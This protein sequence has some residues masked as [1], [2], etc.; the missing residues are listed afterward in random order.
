MKSWPLGIATLESALGVSQLANFN[1]P[2]L[3]GATET[4]RS[5]HLLN[6]SNLQYITNLQHVD[7]PVVHVL[8]ELLE[9][10][11]PDVLE[12]DDRVLVAR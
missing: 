1:E 8:E 9:V 7:L 2:K 5:R 4:G 10:L 12:E 3:T 6:M 11:R